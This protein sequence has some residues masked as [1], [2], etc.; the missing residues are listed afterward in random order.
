MGE[1]MNE[2]LR[3]AEMSDMQWI[4]ED[5]ET[6]VEGWF[7]DEP[8]TT[9]NFLD[10]LE[11]FTMRKQV[12]LGSDTTAPIIKHILAIARRVKKEMGD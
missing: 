3:I 5:I 10:R 11:S 9:H 6:V 1:V 7:A 2:E 8:I 12:C 4:T